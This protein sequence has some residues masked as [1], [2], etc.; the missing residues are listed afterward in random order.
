MTRALI[1][2]A[3]ALARLD[4]PDTVFLDGSWT[5]PGGPRTGADGHVR[6]SRRF[7]I[8]TVKDSANPL[9]H[10]LPDA[11]TF[12]AHARALGLNNTSRLIIYDRYGLFSAAR[13]WWMFRAMG[14]DD[15][16]VLDGGLPAWAVA[17]G[18][19][20]DTIEPTWPEGDFQARFCPQRV[21]DRVAVA[22]AIASGERQILDARGEARFSARTPEPREGMRSGHMPGAHNLPFTTLLHPDGRLRVSAEAFRDVGI[23]L[24][25]PVI[26]SCGSGVTACI[27]SLAL[28][29]LGKESAVYDGSWSE[30]GSRPDTAIEPEA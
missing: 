13:V 14:H 3:E 23:D 25:K 9:P 2:A 6:G 27:L 16:A 26:T 10:M 20:A 7:D 29:C 22:A 17:G 30:W 15:V 28:D 11:D 1:T 18:P 5:F 24:D 21:A 12:T 4:D 8:D 19:I